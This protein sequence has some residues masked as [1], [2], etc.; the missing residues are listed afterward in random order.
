MLFVEVSSDLKGKLSKD[1]VAQLVRQFTWWKSDPSRECESLVFGKDSGTVKPPVNGQP[2]VLRHCHLIPTDSHKRLAW[3]LQFRRYQEKKASSK[4]TSD[5]YLH[6]VQDGDNRF[7]LIDI[8]DD[9]GAH[10]MLMMTNK[11]DRN[12]MNCYAKLAEDFIFGSC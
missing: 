11:E 4:R 9:P 7:L 2:N 5:R 10:H 8:A 1:A 6:Y 12:R 3:E